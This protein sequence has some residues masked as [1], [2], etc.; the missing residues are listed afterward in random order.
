MIKTFLEIKHLLLPNKTVNIS[1]VSVAY[2][3]Y[4]YKKE[5][6][7]CMLKGCFS[8][9]PNESKVCIPASFILDKDFTK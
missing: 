7:I 3:V 9:A 6:V 5:H 1:L 4:S 2:A 8:L